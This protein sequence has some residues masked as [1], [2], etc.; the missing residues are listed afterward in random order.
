MGDP[1]IPPAEYQLETYTIARTVVQSVVD[2]AKM[3]LPPD[4]YHI[5]RQLN[6]IRDRENLE[7]FV[8]RLCYQLDRMRGVVEAAQKLEPDYVDVGAIR[9]T[10]LND[11]LRELTAALRVMRGDE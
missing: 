3:P 9:E 11:R 5:R 1:A 2:D 10:A 4:I 6:G 7:T 8:F